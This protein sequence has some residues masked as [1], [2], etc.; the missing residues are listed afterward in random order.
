ENR[1]AADAE[2]RDVEQQ[3]CLVGEGLGVKGLLVFVAQ[4]EPAVFARETDSGKSAVVQEL[5]QLAGPLPRRRLISLQQRRL[6]QIES[7]HVRGQPRPGP[8]PKFLDRL[9]SQRMASHSSVDLVLG[10]C[11]ATDARVYRL[12]A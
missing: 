2:G 12:A 4:P 5:L 3:R 10:D 7:W 11:T 1:C 9:G 6:G 8:A